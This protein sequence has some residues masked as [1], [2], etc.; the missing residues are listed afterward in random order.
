MNRKFYHN[1]IK[2]QANL[3][4]KYKSSVALS[5]LGDLT[6]PIII[7]VLFIVGVISKDTSYSIP[8]IIIYVV[9]TNVLFTVTM[10]DM[11]NRISYDI[12]SYQLAYK[13]LSPISPLRNY[14]VNDLA[15]KLVKTLTFYVPFL[16]VIAFFERVSV[17]TILLTV[18][19]ILIACS[20]GYSISFIIGTLS[21][22]LT[23]IWGISAIKNL[24]IAAFSGTIFPLYILPEHVQSII[25]KTPFPYI[26]YV[27]TSILMGEHTYINAWNTILTGCLWSFVLL[28]LSKVLWNIGIKKYESVGV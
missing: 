5:F 6:I 11:E 15:I 2:F 24:V 16:V 17:M 4:F 8:K 13:L 28:V 12:R 25:Y 1:A 20:I 22:W 14:I 23:E 9:L 18:I 3:F 26:S 7:N 27:P 21:F 10:T 19:S